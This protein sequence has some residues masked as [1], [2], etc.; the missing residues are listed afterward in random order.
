MHIY[1]KSRQISRI[2]VIS[3]IGTLCIPL[4][5]GPRKCTS[6]RSSN[7]PRPIATVPDIHITVP[8]TQSLSYRPSHCP[9]DPITVPQTQSLSH[10]PSHCPRSNHCPTDPIT[11]PQTQSLSH[12]LS[13]CPTDPITVPQTQ[14]LSHRPSHC[15]TDPITVPC[16]TQAL[17]P[18]PGSLPSHSSLPQT[19]LSQS[20]RHSCPP[21]PD[22]VPHTQILSPRP[23]YPSHG[24]YPVSG[25]ILP[26]CSRRCS[27]ML[28]VIALLTPVT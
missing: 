26:L 10:R 9:T 7:C 22:T 16:Q 17:F 18:R 15:P 13:R 25:W 23:R 20:Y 3:R 12:R 27:Q 8:Q 5:H 28:P 19:L 6:H 14:P 11:V 4:F 21:D 1:G 24:P 2:G